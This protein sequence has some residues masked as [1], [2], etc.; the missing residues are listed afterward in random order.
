[1]RIVRVGSLCELCT[2]RVF[3]LR[4]LLRSVRRKYSRA[5]S[6]QLVSFQRFSFILR[7]MAACFVDNPSRFSVS[8]VLCPAQVRMHP[9][10]LC[11]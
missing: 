8:S 1:M 4:H 2:L 10:S 9:I 3:P 5:V 7:H 11:W 6:A